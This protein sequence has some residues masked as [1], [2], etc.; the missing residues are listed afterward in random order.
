MT[1]NELARYMRVH[2]TTIYRLL[3]SGGLPG[4][5]LG[6]SW[7]FHREA[8][9]RWMNGIEAGDLPAPKVSERVDN[10]RLGRLLFWP[11]RTQHQRRILLE[12]FP[13]RIQPEARKSARNDHQTDAPTLS[14]LS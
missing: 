2:P 10:K 7:R 13:N 14:S 8:I 6:G 11:R 12:G 9:D 4:I 3:K 1:V 5:K